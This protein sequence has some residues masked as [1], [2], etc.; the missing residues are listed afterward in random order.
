MEPLARGRWPFGKTRKPQ[1]L[2]IPA[3]RKPYFALADSFG[4]TNKGQDQKGPQPQTVSHGCA[5]GM[6]AVS[7]HASFRDLLNRNSKSLSV[8][9]DQGLPEGDTFNLHRWYAF[10]RMHFTAAILNHHETGC[11]VESLN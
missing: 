8:D 6:T 5:G 7:L 1:L 4:H 10:Y 3:E 9:N 11:S 2:F